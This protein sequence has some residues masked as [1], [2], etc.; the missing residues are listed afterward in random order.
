MSSTAVRQVWPPTRRAIC[1]APTPF[2]IALRM[3][4]T[5]SEFSP[6]D[7][8]QSILVTLE[9]GYQGALSSWVSTDALGNVYGTTDVG[10]V[11]GQGNVFKLTCCWNYTD[12]HDFAGGP[13]D[14]I[15]PEASPVVDAHGN[16]YGT[17]QYGGLYG[18]GRRLGDFTIAGRAG[19]CLRVN[20]RCTRTN[21][22][23]FRAI[24]STNRCRAY[25][26]ALLSRPTANPFP[27]PRAFTAIA[28]ST[29]RCPAKRNLSPPLFA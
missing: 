23:Y 20:F 22:R 9:L 5:V 26:W 13:N 16:I 1:T 2:R 10:G 21:C 6:P 29:S 17:T 25:P 14:G 3:A 7:F 24:F 11:N 19:E 12:L 4:A 15:Q 18:R 27:G 28:R 8:A